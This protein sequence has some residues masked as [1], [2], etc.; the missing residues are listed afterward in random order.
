MNAKLAFISAHSASHT[1]R[2]LCAVLQ[3]GRGIGSMRAEA[4]IGL[5]N[6]VYNMRRHVE[7]D[8]LRTAPA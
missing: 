5:K 8:R 3:V 4:R 2:R 7:L 1:I 6:L